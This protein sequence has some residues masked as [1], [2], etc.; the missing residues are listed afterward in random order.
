MDQTG[1]SFGV[2]PVGRAMVEE[3][4]TM[5]P[6][7]QSEKMVWY[8]VLVPTVTVVMYGGRVA[9]GRREKSEDV[10]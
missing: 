6:F 8:W 5:V 7:P 4:K 2:F 1:T 9:L 10:A 3:P